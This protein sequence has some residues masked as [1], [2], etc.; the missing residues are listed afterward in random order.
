MKGVLAFTLA[1]LFVSTVAFAAP[2]QPTMLK[3]SAAPTIN[4]AFDGSELQVSYDQTGTDATCVLMIMT[5]GKASSINQITNGNMGWHYMHHVDTTIYFSA[6]QQTGTGTNSFTWSGTNLLGDDVDSDTYEYII[7]GYDHVTTLQP[8]FLLKT[9]GWQEQ[10][11]ILTIDEAGAPLSMPIL[12]DKHE[13]R[14]ESCELAIDPVW[15]W[16]FGED[17][18]DS[19][20]ITETLVGDMYCSTSTWA[21]DPLDFNVFYPHTFNKETLQ[22]Y[23]RKFTWV[24]DDM[25]EQDTD[26]GE[27]D[28]KFIYTASQ[29]GYG[30]YTGGCFSIGHDNRQM[31]MSGLATGAKVAEAMVYWVDMDT[32]EEIRSFDA[33]PLTYR[34]TYDDEGNLT[35]T[36]AHAPFVYSMVDD[37]NCWASWACNFMLVVDPNVEDLDED[38]LLWRNSN[39]DGFSDWGEGIVWQGKYSSQLDGNYCLSS[40]CFD[41]GALSFDLLTPDGTGIG[42]FPYANETAGWKGGCYF[43]SDDTPYDGMYTSNSSTFVEGQKTSAGWWFCAHDSINGLITPEG[44]GVED[45]APAAYSVDQNSPNPCNPTTTIG[46]TIANPGNITIDVYNVAGQKVDTI[47][48]NYMDAGTHSV[49]WDGSNFS[50]GVYFY[51][52][53]SGDFSKTMKMTL[54]K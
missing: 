36:R 16:P 19:T 27:E 54:L 6:P 20:K 23:A 26:W 42:Y 1:L 40:G 47:A 49:V 44:V 35:G 31:I 2:F 9:F 45:A 52:V 30:G 3:F 22:N 24:P 34:E 21:L 37:R 39:G 53:K 10:G 5:H 4:Y 32:G 50:A 41:M 13:T 15:K 7:W 29:L 12:F 48:N 18:E 33:V 38:L 17:P 51:T 28:G 11:R 8:A 14:H 46:F 43:I 25:A